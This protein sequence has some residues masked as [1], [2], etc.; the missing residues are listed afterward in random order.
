MSH[1]NICT[2]CYARNNGQTGLLR[3]NIVASTGTGYIF[4][5]QRDF[6]QQCSCGNNLTQHIGNHSTLQETYLRDVLTTA[7]I[8]KLRKTISAEDRASLNLILRG[9]EVLSSRMA[10]KIKKLIDREIV[11]DI[12]RGW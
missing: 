3:E 12:P 11:L 1:D 2:K 4:A 6:T 8:K 7:E 10:S 5:V 9:K